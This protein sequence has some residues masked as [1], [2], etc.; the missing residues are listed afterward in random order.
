MRSACS[1]AADQIAGDAGGVGRHQHRQLGGTS[2]GVRSPCCS[3]C[4]GRPGEKIRSLIPLPE[5]S[6]VAISVG[7]VDGCRIVGI[8]SKEGDLVRND[9]H[10]RG[11]TGHGQNCEQMKCAPPFYRRDGCLTLRVHCDGGAAE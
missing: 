1:F 6:I 8:R 5:S 9:R 7:V 11:G 4:G 3:T 2:T 10:G